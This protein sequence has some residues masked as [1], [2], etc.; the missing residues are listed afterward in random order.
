M[1]I[2]ENRY[3]KLCGWVLGMILLGAI[4]SGAWDRLLNPLFNSIFRFSIF[5]YTLGFKSFSNS[6]YQ[7]VAKGF[8]E[9]ISLKILYYILGAFLGIA[10]SPLIIIIYRSIQKKIHPR[11]KPKLAL[12]TFVLNIVFPLYT[13][14]IATVIFIS[15]SASFYV[16]NAITYFNQCLAICSPY[17]SNEAVLVF[18]S[19]FAQINSKEAYVDLIHELKSIADSNNLSMPYFEVW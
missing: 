9:L 11:Y 14:L 19:K 18:K 15:L 10:T 6:M 3:I 5:I 2:F 7:E 8:H 1:K 17:M 13:I 16:N 4:G 12:K